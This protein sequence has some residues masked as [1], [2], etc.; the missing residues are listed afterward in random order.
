[1]NADRD[2]RARIIAAALWIFLWGA[3]VMVIVMTWH[4]W[5]IGARAGCPAG[6]RAGW[7]GHCRPG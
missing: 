5:V 6:Q 4:P 2:P 3:V 1:V 7:D